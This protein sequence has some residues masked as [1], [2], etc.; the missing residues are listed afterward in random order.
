MGR[1]SDGQHGI[2][3][4]G[5]T[6]SARVQEGSAQPLLEVLFQGLP[7]WRV[8]GLWQPLLKRP[9]VGFQ[10]GRGQ[11]RKARRGSRGSRCILHN[12]EQWQWCSWNIDDGA[13]N[14]ER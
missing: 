14:A 10:L 4:W 5:G 11:E 7:G 1:G 12:I 6:L 2:G 13:E 9:T 8:P 3:R